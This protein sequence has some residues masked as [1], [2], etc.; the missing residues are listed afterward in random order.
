MPIGLAK[1]GL[2]QCC[3]PVKKSH[4]LALRQPSFSLK[5]AAKTPKEGPLWRHAKRDHARRAGTQPNCTIAL[6]IANC[7]LAPLHRITDIT[8][9]A[10][11][12]QTQ[13]PN[14]TCDE[15]MFCRQYHHKGHLFRRMCRPKSADQVIVLN[16]KFSCAYAIKRFIFHFIVHTT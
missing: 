1:N 7:H 3:A 9:A 2:Q 11:K 15:H 6:F 16:A 8:A 14:R 10:N 13:K 4:K 5:A 12:V